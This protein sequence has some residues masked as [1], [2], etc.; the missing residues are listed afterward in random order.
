MR[1]WSIALAVCCLWSASCY[2][3]DTA[4]LTQETCS[5]IAQQRN[6][7]SDA[8]AVAEARRKLAQERLDQWET[9]FKAY[10]G[11]PK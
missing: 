7:L 11:E 6:S 1:R 3:E 9:Y 8:M 4:R 5:L 2:A 10:A